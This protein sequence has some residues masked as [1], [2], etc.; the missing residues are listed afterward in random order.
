MSYMPQRLHSSLNN[1]YIKDMSK[2]M[3]FCQ[4]SSY[5]KICVE[6]K[7]SSSSNKWPFNFLVSD[8]IEIHKFMILATYVI[9]NSL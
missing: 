2:M 6:K 1:K 7:V 5:R 8:V 4:G 3:S 9:I